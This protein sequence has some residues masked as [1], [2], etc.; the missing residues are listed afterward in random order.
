MRRQLKT[1]E[2]ICDCCKCKQ[3]VMG[4]SEYDSRPDGWITTNSFCGDHECRGGHEN[5]FCISCQRIA[6]EKHK[7]DE[8]NYYGTI[9]RHLEKK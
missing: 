4:M 3:I 1:F 9:L 8:D 6:Q 2:W 7:R 5:D